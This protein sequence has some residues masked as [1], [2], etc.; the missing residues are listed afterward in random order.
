MNVRT[1]TT[2]VKD[3]LLNFASGAILV[4]R[5]QLWQSHCCGDELTRLSIDYL[6]ERYLVLLTTNQRN[7]GSGFFK[8]SG[9]HW[10]A[11]KS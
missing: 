3:L 1:Q 9:C 6:S 10:T 4:A 8:S 7:V 5:A 2:C 11:R